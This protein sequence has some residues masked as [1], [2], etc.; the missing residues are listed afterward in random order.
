[1]LLAARLVRLP[2]AHIDQRL[3]PPKR[4]ASLWQPPPTK[5]NPWIVRLTNRC[6][7]LRRSR[8]RPVDPERRAVDHIARGMLTQKAQLTLDL[9]GQQVIVG[10]EILQPLALGKLKQTI[11][12]DIA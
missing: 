4:A 6:D 1:M 11:P 9:Q 3:P 7:L 10:I 8:F 12:G 5:Q 2:S